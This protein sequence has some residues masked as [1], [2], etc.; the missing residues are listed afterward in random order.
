MER[1]VLINEIAN[2]CFYYGLYNR[3][4][5]ISEIKSNIEYQLRNCEFIEN[6]INMINVN[7]RKR[8][9]VDIQKLI[10]ILTELERLRLEIEYNNIDKL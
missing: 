5:N 7:I 6:L 3:P 2:F 9:N 8:K 1:K 4:I 10:D